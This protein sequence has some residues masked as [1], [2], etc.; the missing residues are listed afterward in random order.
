MPLL[1]GHLLYAGINGHFFRRFLLS[2]FRTRSAA[3]RVFS[4]S[5]FHLES[6]T[7]NTL[8]VYA[9]AVAYLDTIQ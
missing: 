1:E 3:L 2:S 6:H 5:L 7:L 9:L 4:F 8:I